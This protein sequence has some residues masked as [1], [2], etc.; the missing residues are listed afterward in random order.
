MEPT[1]A[2]VQPIV[3]ARR[4]A[5]LQIGGLALLA[6]WVAEA[7][8][9]RSG[10]RVRGLP[11]SSGLR[12]A[13]TPG[14]RGSGTCRRG[15][16]VS[17]PTARPDHGRVHVRAHVARGA[18]ASSGCLQAGRALGVRRAPALV[19]RAQRRPEADLVG[20]FGARGSRSPGAPRSVAEAALEV[21]ER[22]LHARGAADHVLE[23]TAQ[24]VALLSRRRAGG[25][26]GPA[27]PRCAG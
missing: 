11:L 26:R 16:A 19:A 14:D 21:A 6:G 18:R 10:L 9:G 7:A 3:L 20:L 1:L 27:P 4:H 15:S 23:L 25:A 13:C 5:L 2:F 22:L 12:S 8:P 17:G 24:L